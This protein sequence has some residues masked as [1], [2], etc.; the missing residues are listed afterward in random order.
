MCTQIKSTITKNVFNEANGAILNAEIYVVGL[1]T[2]SFHEPS[3]KEISFNSFIQI[4]HKINILP[5]SI[6]HFFSNKLFYDEDWVYKCI[7]C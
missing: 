5:K 3:F 2:L 1:R 7:G 4:K 6:L